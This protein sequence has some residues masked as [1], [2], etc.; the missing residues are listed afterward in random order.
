MIGRRHGSPS[1]G[2]RRDDRH[3]PASVGSQSRA[4]SWRYP[5]S[6]RDRYRRY[7]DDRRTGRNDGDGFREGTRR[8]RRPD[9]RDALLGVAG[10][11]RRPAGRADRPGPGRG[12]LDLFERHHGLPE[13]R[14]AH[15]PQPRR[16]G[17]RHGSRRGIPRGRRLA[18]APPLFPSL[19]F[20]PHLHLRS[21][22]RRHQHRRAPF[23]A[24]S[25][26]PAGA[27]VSSDPA[28]R[29]P[30]GRARARQ[31]A[32]C[33]RLRPLLGA[34]R[35]QRG[36]PPRRGGGPGSGPPPGLPGQAGLRPQRGRSRNRPP[37]GSSAAASSSANAPRW[38]EGAEG[39][40]GNSEGRDDGGA[41]A[42]GSGRRHAVGSG[43]LRDVRRPPAA[44][45]A[46][47]AR[48][49]SPGR[50]GDRLRPGLRH[51]RGDPSHGRAVAGGDGLRPRQLG[52]DAGPGG[53]GAEPGALDRGRHRATG[54]P[55]RRP[56]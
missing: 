7:I 40:E 19:R 28:L 51:G 29:G 6:P 13:G 35:G 42:P 10:G 16:R 33:R 9:P 34:G 56:I 55:R 46:G 53:D 30:P 44:A 18:R 14:A 43:A 31:A 24:R 41:V 26:P 45:R 27:G 37:A 32:D 20:Q 38:P 36:R 49:R 54:S 47:I 1:C 12:H 39:D 11:A 23:R 5:R 17:E 8:D 25:V 4:R 52:G 48:S 2:V 3:G 50:A 22:L 21:R 15:A